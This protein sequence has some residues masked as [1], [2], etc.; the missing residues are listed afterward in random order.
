MIVIYVYQKCGTCRKALKWLTLNQIPH[1]V[2]S[3]RETPPLPHEIQS[4]LLALNGDIRKIFN[5][6]GIDYRALDLK[7]Q[8]A[9]MSEEKVIRLLAKNGNLVKRPFL[10]GDGKFL[11]G[12]NES[13][14]Q[15][16]LG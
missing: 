16:A 15:K 2:K 11:V 5:T 9:T 1:E 7:S 12:F 10:I 3:I 6:S 13:D 8:M 14:W 4:A